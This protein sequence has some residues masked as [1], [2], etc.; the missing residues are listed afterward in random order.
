VPICVSVPSREYTSL[1]QEA[2]RRGTS[3]PEVIRTK[4]R[5][6]GSSDDDDDE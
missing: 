2:Q 6:R 4:M 3:V 1:L 5:H